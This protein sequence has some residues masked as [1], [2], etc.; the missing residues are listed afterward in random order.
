MSFLKLGK[1]YTVAGEG[2]NRWLVPTSALMIHLCVGMGYGM[3]VFWLPMSRLVGVSQGLGK[4][5]ACPADM[6]FFAQL[7][8]T[9]CDW[10]V[11]MCSVIFGIL[12][13][14]LGTT[15]AILGN[16]LE[17]VGPRKCGLASCCCFCFFFFMLAVATFTHQL[18]IAW[19]SA[20]IGGIGLGLGYITP[21]STL[22]KWF[23]DRVGMATGMA[24]GG[25]G[26]G[27]MV[28]APLAQKLI[29]FFA[30]PTSVGLWQAFFV[31]ACCYTVM[32]LLGCFTI[33]VAPSGYKPAGW[34]PKNTGNMVD[35]GHGG[36]I[37]A[38]SFNVS[39]SKAVRT[40]QFWFC[41]FMLFLNIAAGIGVLAMASPLLQEVFA[42]NLIGMPGVPF[43]QLT[44][45][46]KGQVAMIAAGFTGLLS[47]FNIGGRV[48]WA[49]L[50]DKL[51]RKT[52][53]FI[54]SIVGAILY[55]S[56]PTLASSLNLILFLCAVCV[57]IS[58]YGGGFSTIPAYLADLFGTQFVGAIHG[59]LLTAW[60]TAGLLSPLLINI[61]R[62][63]QLNAGV[64][65]AQ[66]YSVTLYIMAVLLVI[67]FFFAIMIRP[68]NSKYYMTEEEVKAAKAELEE[69]VAQ[70]QASGVVPPAK[71]TSA[72]TMIIC[73]LIVGIPLLWGIYQVVLQTAKM[74]A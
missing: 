25:F 33:K 63:M 23:P 21:V 1:E 35:D 28:G 68:V 26:G 19:V 59:R 62:D 16:W 64:A 56:I 42:G 38:S 54:Y 49:S 7:F 30:T 43:D 69:K 15:T 44:D 55:A 66:A 12:F 51:G 72:G 50:S 4:A 24:V 5:L 27:A 22:I 53:Y 67:E 32:M 61:I 13:F 73:W 65:K 9:Q 17:H 47:L 36:L 39:T 60:S 46:Q 57:C 11:V 70:A 52:V 29:A 8:T 34:V 45:G 20:I 74:F 58:F 48:V 40:P 31:M 18:W 37:E 10:K 2:F 6:S 41:W 14:M 3:S 71:P